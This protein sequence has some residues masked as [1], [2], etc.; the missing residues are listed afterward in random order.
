MSMIYLCGD[1]HCDIDVSKLN[2]K[3][4]PEQ[5]RLSKQDVVLICGDFGAVWGGSNSRGDE[6]WLK[7]HDQKKYTTLFIDG[8]H[9]NH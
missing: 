1:T 7:W 9:E 8:N 6:W 4:F 2:T 5:N 3:N